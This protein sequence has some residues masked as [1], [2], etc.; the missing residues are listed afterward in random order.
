M[1]KV[2]N[3]RR[4][5]L[6]MCFCEKC[7]EFYAYILKGF[8]LIYRYISWLPSSSNT[9]IW[10]FLTLICSTGEYT[11][12]WI[13]EA[14]ICMYMWQ[15]IRGYNMPTFNIY[16][17]QLPDNYILPH[18]PSH[19]VAVSYDNL[20]MQNLSLQESHLLSWYKWNELIHDLFNGIFWCQWFKSE[21]V[22]GF[23]SHASC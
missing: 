22:Y 1:T 18:V 23:V 8:Q 9:F 14:K 7:C 2:W 13:Q 16:H 3:S 11:A 6:K 5:C 20:V 12:V 19:T 10:K 15:L 4:V 21:W 17:L